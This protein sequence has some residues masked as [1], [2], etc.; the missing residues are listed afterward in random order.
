ML[1][2]Q[3]A[4]PVHGEVEL[5]WAPPVYGEVELEQVPPVYGEVELEQVP[6]AGSTCV[7]GG[8]VGVHAVGRRYH[9]KVRSV[10]LIQ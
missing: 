1:V 4:P 10:I 6:R 8:R 9:L 5:E 7:W 2:A 3:R